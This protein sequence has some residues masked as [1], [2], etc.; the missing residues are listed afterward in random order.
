MYIRFS[1]VGVD[2][3]KSLNYDANT[4]NLTLTAI[5]TLTEEHIE[6]ANIKEVI[7]VYQ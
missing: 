4:L 3:G 1:N 2:L 6:I 5:H 7:T